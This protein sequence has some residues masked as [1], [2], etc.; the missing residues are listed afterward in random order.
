MKFLMLL[1]PISLFG[2]DL[3]DGSRGISQITD[4]N[5]ASL[6]TEAQCGKV[7]C[8]LIDLDFML[9][10]CNDELGPVYLKVKQVEERYIVFLNAL[11]IHMKQSDGVT[12]FVPKKVKRTFELPKGINKDNLY[13]SFL[14]E[15]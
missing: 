11:N 8:S 7:G 9:Y 10:G 13:F 5:I 14:E 12:C 15:N 2:Y 6:T 3:P 1:I 4:I